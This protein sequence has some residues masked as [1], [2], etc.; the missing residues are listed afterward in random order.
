MLRIE[1]TFN[2][3]QG[4]FIKDDVFMVVGYVV[5]NISTNII[6]LDYFKTEEEAWLI[7]KRQ[8]PK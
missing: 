1:N 3:L 2:V 7:L 4:H 5:V 8:K 6:C